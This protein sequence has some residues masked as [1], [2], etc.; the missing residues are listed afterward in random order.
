MSG[1][2]PYKQREKSVTSAIMRAIKGRENRAEMSLRKALWRR[3]LRYRVY[4]SSLVGKP[5]IVFVRARVAIFIDGDY[6]HGRTL[7]EQGPRGLREVIRGDGFDY[8][9]ERFEKNIERDDRVTSAL[10]NSGWTVVRLWESEVLADVEASA[11]RMAAL[12]R[13]MR[14]RSLQG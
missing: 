6:W 7:R 3:G 14:A 4:D 10:R 12:V 13:L 2:R 5:D 1:R 8:W 9:R 11:D